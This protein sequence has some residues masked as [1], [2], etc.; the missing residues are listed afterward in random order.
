[1]W[2]IAG[3]LTASGKPLLANDP[4]LELSLPSTWY[5]AR[6]EFEGRVLAGATAPGVP[7]IVI[8]R[9]EHVAWGFTT[10][11]ADTQDLF[12]ETLL[13]NGQYAT[14]EGP[15]PLITRQ[16]VIRVKDAKPVTIEVQATRHGPLVD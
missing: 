7:I 16:E 12:V 9:N 13:D 10:A 15:R 14:P 5:L 4:H 3:R 8:G 1:N 2:V 6:I 11:Y